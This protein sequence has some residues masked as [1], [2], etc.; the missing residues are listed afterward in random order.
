MADS[1]INNPIQRM[2]TWHQTQVSEHQAAEL[3]KQQL[4]EQQRKEENERL[5]NATLEKF[6]RGFEHLSKLDGANGVMTRDSDARPGQV[7]VQG[8]GSLRKT[9]SGFVMEL[10]EF[11]GNQTLRIGAELARQG[12]LA[13]HGLPGLPAPGPKEEV[14]TVDQASN[15][16]LYQEFETTVFSLPSRDREGREGKNLVKSYTLDLN[17]QE[18][19]KNPIHTKFGIL[20]QEDGNLNQPFNRRDEYFDDRRNWRT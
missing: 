1:T 13:L 5:Y 10:A 9:D 11:A 20:H 8:V 19:T 12:A 16:I 17:S 3:K 4:L 7:E 2:A 18:L 15:T 14:F 6:E